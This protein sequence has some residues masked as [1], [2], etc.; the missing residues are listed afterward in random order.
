VGLFADEDAAGD[1]HNEA[2]ELM[3][4]GGEGKG[5]V[6]ELV[7]DQACAGAGQ[8]EA[9]HAVVVLL[10]MKHQNLLLHFLFCFLISLGVPALKL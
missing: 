6:Y 3:V 7:Q 4:G 2:P 8:G 5:T 10:E 1:D 9:D